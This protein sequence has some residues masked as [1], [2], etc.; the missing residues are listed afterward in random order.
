[1]TN[2]GF[3]LL[4]KPGDL[5]G[6]KWLVNY[7]PENWKICIKHSVLGFDD[8]RINSIT[9]VKMGDK[10]L[11]YTHGIKI[12][13]IFEVTSASYHDTSKLWN[14]GLYPN[15][16]KIRNLAVTERPIN[17]KGV[18]DIYL[19][20]I[21]DLGNYFRQS[22]RGLPNEEF[23][24][25]QAELARNLNQLTPYKGLVSKKKFQVFII[26]YPDV[27][28]VTS[29]KLN[30][31]GWKE[32]KR[33]LNVGDK[34]FVYNKTKRQIETCFEV[35]SKRSLNTNTIWQDEVRENKII[36]PNRWDAQILCDGLDVTLDDTRQIEP[37]KSNRRAFS[38]LLRSES[39]RSIDA[40]EFSTFRN[41]LLQRCAITDESPVYTMEILC[42]NT[43][44]GSS[45]FKELEDILKGKKQV[46]LS[47]PPGPG[48]T[49]LAIEFSKY[50]VNLSGSL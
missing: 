32:Q 2:L 50:L 31:L 29:K 11:G 20:F 35:K 19:G 18:Y 24:I 30:V 7:S 33:S 36:Y 42:Q 4:N 49:F 1:M 38:H 3:T 41:L 23:A 39:P 34:V 48:K 37:F 43:Y 13:G 8:R 27:N 12:V 26:G 5:G 14:S 22:L 25:F 15:R 44:L 40:P 21:G 9:Q 6:T 46:I 45:Y 16:V 10:I 17:V 28:L 47:G